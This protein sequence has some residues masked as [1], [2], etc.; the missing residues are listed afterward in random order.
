M[1]A[2]EYRSRDLKTLIAVTAGEKT[3]ELA[4]RGELSESAKTIAVTHQAVLVLH[5]W[6]TPEEADR[7]R[8]DWLDNQAEEFQSTQGGNLF[9]VRE[10][11]IIKNA[12]FKE[13]L[14]NLREAIDFAR[15]A[16]PET[17]TIIGATKEEP[18]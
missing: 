3:I 15:G 1:K 9:W 10:W 12:Q 4:Q 17:F 13:G 7:A 8:L 14:F 18:K 6:E 2:Y 11:R 5:E 16:P